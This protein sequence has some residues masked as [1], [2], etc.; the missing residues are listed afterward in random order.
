[1]IWISW[2]NVSNLTYSFQD[3]L[4]FVASDCEL[5]I[6]IDSPSTERTKVS[7]LLRVGPVGELGHAGLITAVG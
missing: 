6:G 5:T 4:H 7:N 3:S 2:T 1:M